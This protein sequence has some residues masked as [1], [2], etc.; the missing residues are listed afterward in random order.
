MNEILRKECTMMLLVVILL[1][2]FSMYLFMKKP[3]KIEKIE[4]TQTADVIDGTDYI[5]HN[6]APAFIEVINLECCPVCRSNKRITYKNGLTNEKREDFI[7]IDDINFVVCADC[8][9]V[10]VIKKEIK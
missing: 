6:Q 7:Q 8:G 4:V 10:Y 9:N 2:V 1:A 5:L 3:H